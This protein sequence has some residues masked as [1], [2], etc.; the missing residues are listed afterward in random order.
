[1]YNNTSIINTKHKINKSQNYEL[2]T[3]DVELDASTRENVGNQ[4]R[5]SS[6]ND[7]KGVPRMLNSFNMKIDAIRLALFVK[8]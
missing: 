4:W 6:L 1:M 7:L 5:G 2:D 8:E 3:V